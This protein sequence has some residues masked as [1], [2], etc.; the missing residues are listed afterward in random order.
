M[1]TPPCNS[2]VEWFVLLDKLDVSQQQLNYFPVL[3]GLNSNVRGLQ[4]IGDRV[5]KII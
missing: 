4:P 1:T 2:N 5:P 3:F